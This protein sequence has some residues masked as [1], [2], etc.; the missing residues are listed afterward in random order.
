M[1]KHIVQPGEGLAG[2]AERWGFFPLTIWD[3]PGN[4]AL[5]ATREDPDILAAGDELV[6]PEKEPRVEAVATGRRHRFRR[7]GVPAILRV[8]VVLDGVPRANQPYV[9]EVDGA[10]RSGSTDDR[11]IVK[12]YV[13]SNAR[14]A[15]LRIA[16]DNTEIAI[17][18]GYVEPSRRCDGVQSRLNNMGYPCGPVDGQP[19]E[20][21]RKAVLQFQR[22]AGIPESGEWDD[23]AVAAALVRYHDT[24]A[25]QAEAP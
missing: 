12:E 17:A 5:R 19:S 3:H 21:L 9:L 8:Q 1:P 11:G 15:V 14:R 22:D 16:P 24:P 4:A 25:L 10:A 23:P 7:K 13:A 2:I 6:I 18:L 20:R